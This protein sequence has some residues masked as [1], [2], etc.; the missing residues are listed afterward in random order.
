MTKRR[1]P[2]IDLKSVPYETLT[3]AQKAQLDRERKKA[4]ELRRTQLMLKRQAAHKAKVTRGLTREQ[5]LERDLRT[6]RARASKAERALEREKA[7]NLWDE[8][9]RRVQKEKPQLRK[10]HAKNLD[11]FRGLKNPEALDRLG[12]TLEEAVN[13]LWI[14]FE[15][16][17]IYE[18]IGDIFDLYAAEG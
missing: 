11:I 3:P 12:S 15:D 6:A 8:M 13:Q 14:E 1:K 10:I 4:V 17:D 2:P 7:K 16:F 18:D 5:R 9:Y